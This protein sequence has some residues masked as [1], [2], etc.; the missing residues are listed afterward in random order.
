MRRYAILT[1]LALLLAA[2]CD[3]AVQPPIPDPPGELAVY[4]VVQAWDSTQYAVVTT[5]R[6]ADQQP[7]QFVQDA[8]VQI[9]EQ[10]LTVVPEDSIQIGGYDPLTPPGERR[11]NYRT[12]SLYVAPG[13]T[14]ELRAT[15]EEKTVSGTAQ[16]PGAF[17]GTVDSMTVHWEPSAGAAGYRVRVRRYEDGDTAWE[18]VTTTRNTAVVVDREGEYGEFQAGEHAVFIAAVDSN[19]MAYRERNVRR[20]GVEGGFGVFGAIT[21]IAGTLPLPAVDT[22]AKGRSESAP[23]RPLR[24]RP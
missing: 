15:Q 2:G 18:F 5:P 16:V 8:T 7:L 22:T 20:S 3:T 13:E 17:R 24:E 11:A 6:A 4:S 9:D 23:L 21:R 12:D 14:V 19:L 1:A 10:A